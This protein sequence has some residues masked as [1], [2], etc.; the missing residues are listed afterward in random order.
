MSDQGQRITN[1]TNGMIIQSAHRSGFSGRNSKDIVTKD[2]IKLD[3]DSLD[4]LV[5][6]RFFC[7]KFHL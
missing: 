7:V 4:L 1:H 5:T 3:M 2:K 6:R